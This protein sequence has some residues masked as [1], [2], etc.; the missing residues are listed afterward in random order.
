[1]AA[2]RHMMQHASCVTVCI[3]CSNRTWRLTTWRWRHS[4]VRNRSE[5]TVGL[6]AAGLRRAPTCA[7]YRQPRQVQSV[8]AAARADHAKLA[9]LAPPAARRPTSVRWTTRRAAWS[10]RCRRRR[11]PV[12]K[13]VIMSRRADDQRTCSVRW[14]PDALQ[15][16]SK[17]GTSFSSAS[18]HDGQHAVLEAVCRLQRRQRR[19]AFRIGMIMIPAPNLQK[20]LHMHHPSFQKGCNHRAAAQCITQV[21]TTPALASCTTAQW[22]HL[23]HARHIGAGLWE[24]AAH[25]SSCCAVQGS[26]EVKERRWCFA[27]DPQAIEQHHML[28][29]AAVAVT[30]NSS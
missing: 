1:M 20:R 4:S 8:R 19:C 21:G 10:C 11:T 15:P 3:S 25:Y 30:V 27:G 29:C 12:G 9:F 2:R 23:Q 13:S 7:S 14:C 28:V 17:V 22:P 24:R 16:M 18:H 6:H 5:P 26:G